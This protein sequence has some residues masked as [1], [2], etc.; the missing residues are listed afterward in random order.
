[1]SQYPCSHI[2]HPPSLHHQTPLT[3]PPPFHCTTSPSLH[4]PSSPSLRFQIMRL[5]HLGFN[6][7]GQ[8]IQQRVSVSGETVY[9]IS[10]KGTLNMTYQYCTDK[11]LKCLKHYLYKQSTYIYPKIRKLGRPVTTDKGCK[12][13]RTIK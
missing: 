8:Q 2:T 11:V 12:D 6:S 5:N 7:S 4:H 9:C 1:M 13:I 3:A 10:G